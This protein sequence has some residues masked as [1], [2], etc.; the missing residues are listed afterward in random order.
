MYQNQAKLGNFYE[1]L[2]GLSY[3]ILKTVT[4]FLHKNCRHE[5]SN[6]N[7]EKFASWFTIYFETLDTNPKAKWKDLKMYNYFGPTITK[8][9][10]EETGKLKTPK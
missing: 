2:G 8:V 9:S 3:S 7:I 6:F 10:R 5:D 4:T 1:K